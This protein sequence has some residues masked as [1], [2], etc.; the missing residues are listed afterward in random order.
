MWLHV[1]FH[2]KAVTTILFYFASKWSK[3][4]LAICNVGGI[5]N[6]AIVIHNSR[7]RDCEENKSTLTYFNVMVIVSFWT[8]YSTSLLCEISLTKVSNKIAQYRPDHYI[9]HVYHVWEILEG[10]KLANLANYEPF[11]NYFCFRNTEEYFINV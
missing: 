7:L 9:L 5:I 2:R 10:G 1:Y 4:I 6:I 3:Y 8:K 11:A